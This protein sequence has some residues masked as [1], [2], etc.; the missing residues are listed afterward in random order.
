MAEEK[1]KPAA[2]NTKGCGTRRAVCGEAV[3]EWGLGD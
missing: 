1:S 3:S 2:F